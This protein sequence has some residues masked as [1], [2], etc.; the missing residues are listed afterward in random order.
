MKLQNEWGASL[1]TC[2]SL[3]HIPRKYSSIALGKLKP[4]PSAK[5]K[6]INSK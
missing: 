3:K 4:P 1:T 5:L 6:S 2:N